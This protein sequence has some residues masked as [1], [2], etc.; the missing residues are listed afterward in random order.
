MTTRVDAVRPMKVLHQKICPRRQPLHIGV[1]SSLLQHVHIASDVLDRLLVKSECR[2]LLV[3]ES[4][5]HLEGFSNPIK[6]EAGGD[7]VDSLFNLLNMLGHFHTC[8]S[9]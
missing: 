5:L 7:F 6:T 1:A 8:W 3:D 2:Q 9:K 4:D